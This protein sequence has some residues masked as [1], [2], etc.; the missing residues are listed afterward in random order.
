MGKRIAVFFLLA[1]LAQAA[2]PPCPAGSTKKSTT[3]GFHKLG[4]GPWCPTTKVACVDDLRCPQLAPLM[5]QEGE[6]QY[7]VRGFNPIGQGRFCPD[8]QAVCVDSFQCP[9]LAPILCNKGEAQY[10]VT[11]FYRLKNGLYCPHQAAA[12]VEQDR[13]PPQPPAALPESAPETEN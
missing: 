13:C 4:N 11:G 2:A 5:C 6:A 3:V 8:I 1:G 10:R 9:Q 7:Y 12:C